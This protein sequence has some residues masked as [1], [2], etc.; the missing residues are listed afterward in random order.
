MK[1]IQYLLFLAFFLL[2]AI[3]CSENQNFQGRMNPEDR[4][5]Q[6]K[7]TLDLTDEQTEKVEQIYQESQELMSQMREQF[8]GDRSQMREQMMKSRE[9]INKK[10]EGIL[11]EDQ[12]VLYHEYMEEREQFRRERRGQR[13]QQ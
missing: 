6:L 2:S 12:I 3:Y 1:K 9:E 7:E 13:Q 10:I 4:A 8:Q 5:A 11:Y